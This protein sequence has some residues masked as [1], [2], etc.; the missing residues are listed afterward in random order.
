MAT[1][2]TV[3]ETHLRHLPTILAYKDTLSP[4]PRPM[5]GGTF[6]G[7]MVWEVGDDGAHYVVILLPPHERSFREMGG[8]FGQ[9]FDGQWRIVTHER[10]GSIEAVH[11]MPPWRP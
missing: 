11:V 4:E 6:P 3:Q 2:A 9:H 8:Y 10:Y 1:A 7:G 5:P